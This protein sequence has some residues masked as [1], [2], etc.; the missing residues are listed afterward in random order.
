MIDMVW[1]DIIYTY[2]VYP[3]IYF[4]S[5]SEDLNLPSDIKVSIRDHDCHD[6]VEKLYY[7]CGYEPVCIYCGE[8]LQ[9]ADEEGT[10]YPQCED[11]NEAR[12]S[13]RE[14]K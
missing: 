6:P 11:C 5:F 4:S 12:I 3:H 7:S 13:R 10:H 14:K 2:E 8:Y 1:Y 9:G